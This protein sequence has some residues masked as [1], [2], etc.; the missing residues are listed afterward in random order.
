MEAKVKEVCTKIKVLNLSQGRLILEEAELANSFGQRLKGLL[1][2]KYLPWGTGLVIF[3]C[4]SVHTLGMSFPL[5]IGFVN[6]EG[7]LCRVYE[8]VPTQKINLSAKEAQYAIEAPAGTFA[9]TRTREN[10]RIGLK[11]L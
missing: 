3:P 10:D 9:I 1:G 11:V 8:S 6:Q 4:R 5:D 2:R 7:R